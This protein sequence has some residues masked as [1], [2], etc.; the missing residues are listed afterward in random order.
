MTASDGMTTEELYKTLS[1]LV[2]YYSYYD[3]GIY[4]AKVLIFSSKCK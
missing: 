2:F 4:L 3:D 1:F